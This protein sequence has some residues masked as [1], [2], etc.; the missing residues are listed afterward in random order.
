MR[1]QNRRPMEATNG[2]K[3][4]K[5]VFYLSIWLCSNI[6]LN[7]T[8]TDLTSILND[9][10]SYKE[11]FNLFEKIFIQFFFGIIRSHLKTKYYDFNADF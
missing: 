10:S 7:L 8:L 3:G 1:R 2:I 6:Q 9:G 4:E 11:F 5:W